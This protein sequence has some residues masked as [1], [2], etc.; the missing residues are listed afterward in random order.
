MRRRSRP[1]RESVGAGVGG[2]VIAGEDRL[3]RLAPV[4]AAPARVSRAGQA[5]AHIEGTQ[6]V[7]YS[8]MRP[9]CP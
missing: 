5:S 2:A 7:V 3:A 8:F 9:W 6:P 1:S 4:A